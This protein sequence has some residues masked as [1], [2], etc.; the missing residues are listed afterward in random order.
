MIISYLW[1]SSCT[2][3]IYILSSIWFFTQLGLYS[4]EEAPTQK[5]NSQLNET[6]NDFV[7]G[8]NTNAIAI[9]NETSEPQ[10]N[11]LL[12]NFGNNIIGENSGCQDQIIEKSIDDKIRKAVDNA[13]MTVESRV[14]DASLT[15]MDNVVMPWVEMAVRSITESSV[16]GRSCM[17]QNPDQLDLIGNT[18]NTPL[19]SI[20]LTIW[21]VKAC[22]GIRFDKFKALTEH[23][24]LSKTLSGD[25]LSW[26]RWEGE[27]KVVSKVCRSAAVGSANS[28]YHCY[29]SYRYLTLRFEPI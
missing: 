12:N 26:H 22:V 14:A 19:M 6:L 17:I 18:K 1:L 4:E 15:A 23:L 29:C 11:G 24:E 28:E 9:E 16:R 21:F 5:T 20:L 27:K 3:L 2:L 7:I 8:N 25:D 10:T 13:V